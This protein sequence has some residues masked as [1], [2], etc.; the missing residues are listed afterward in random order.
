MSIFSFKN[1]LGIRIVA[2][3]TAMMSSVSTTK[4]MISSVPTSMHTSEESS[5]YVKAGNRAL[6]I[7]VNKGSLEEVKFVVRNCPNSIDR[8]LALR[9]AAE[10]GDCNIVEYLLS[11][12][13]P[14]DDIGRALCIAVEKNYFNIVGSLLPCVKNNPVTIDTT[15]RI[16]EERGIGAVVKA[17]LLPETGID[18]KCLLIPPTI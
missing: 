2:A 15:L 11:V 12:K 7:A 6:I 14:S 5:G 18:P 4:A 8:G 17:L 9:T 10:K 13:I 16:A 1:K 3:V